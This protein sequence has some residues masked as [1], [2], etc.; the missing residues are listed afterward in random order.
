MDKSHPLCPLMVVRS[1]DIDKGSFRDLKRMLKNFLVQKYHISV[2][3]E[4]WCILIIIL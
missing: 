1:L 4:H 2:L 3:V